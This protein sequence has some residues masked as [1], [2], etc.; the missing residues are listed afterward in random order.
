MTQ[1]EQRREHILKK[2][3]KKSARDCSIHQGFTD[4]VY[5]EQGV[6]GPVLPTFT[7][8]YPEMRRQMEP[9]IRSQI[10]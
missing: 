1:P 2:K 8:T 3:K 10:K 7:N 4:E 6:E 5:G 9:T